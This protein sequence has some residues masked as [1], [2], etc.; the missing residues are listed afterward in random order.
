MYF[1]ELFLSFGGLASELAAS[2]V[3]LK[4]RQNMAV[5]PTKNRFKLFTRLF[6]EAE[7]EYKENTSTIAPLKA[8]HLQT[9]R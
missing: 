7:K 4:L 8:L 9:E 5:N 3:D 1:S 6:V 2:T